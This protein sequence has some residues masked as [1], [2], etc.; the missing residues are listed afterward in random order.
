ML[1]LVNIIY[2][3][4]Q[5]RGSSV[6]KYILLLAAGKIDFGATLMGNHGN[7]AHAGQKT[8]WCAAGQKNAAN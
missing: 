2:T 1:S 6:R 5:K 7:N 4:M 8:S 3:W